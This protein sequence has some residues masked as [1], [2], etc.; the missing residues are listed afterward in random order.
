MVSGS[1]DDQV[2]TRLTRNLARTVVALLPLALTPLLL[3]LIAY[4]VIDLGGGEKDIVWLFPWALWSLIFAATSFYLWQRGWSAGRAF[5]RATLIGLAGIG[6]A[7][8]VLAAAGKLGV[9]GRF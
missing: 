5:V 9:A 4:G 1:F 8:L 6:A 2:M 7:A 3:H